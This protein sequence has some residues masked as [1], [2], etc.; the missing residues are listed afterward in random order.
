MDTQNMTKISTDKQKIQELLTRGVDE[1]IGFEE[2][3][4]KLT[5]GKQLR[6][7]L[8]IDP[9]SPDLHV[10]RSVPLLKLR[11]FQ[12]LGHQIIFIVGS[13]TGVV[14]DASDKETE[15]PMLDPE[16]VERNM[17]AYKEQAGKIIDLD[18]AEVRF[19]HEWLEPLGYAEIGKQANVFSVNEFISRELIKKRLDAGKRIS[20]REMLYPLMQGY[21]SV[22]VKA[23]V[24]LGGTDQRFNMLAGRVLQKEYGQEP[25]AVITNPLYAGLDGRK[26][27]SSWG[28]T[29]NFE[30]E[31][32][33]MF[34]KVMSL[35]DGLLIDYFTAMTRTPLDKIAEY[36]QQL[37]GGTNPKDIKVALGKALVAQYYS[38]EAGEAAAREFEKVFSQKKKPTD[39]PKAKVGAGEYILLDLVMQC[40]LFSS[41]SEARRKIAEG[42]VRIQD[43][44]KQD[45]DERVVVSSGDVLQVGKRKFIQI[46]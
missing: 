17:K 7:K 38:A 18:K 9:T 24:E 11:D 31:P 29:I 34:G 33:D 32:N 16:V 4:K 42:A 44:K 40:N 35:S 23:D 46:P 25:Q 36:K 39:I 20:L 30:D 8:G 10:G 22:V 28:N 43:E 5:S 27:S 19:N 14:G 12:E 13:F 3:E 21:D 37:D 2:L 45:Q 41:K 15:R 6:V 26:M 1:V